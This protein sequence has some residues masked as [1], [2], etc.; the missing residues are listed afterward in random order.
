MISLGK[1]TKLDLTK[2]RSI[3]Q[4]PAL[5]TN[6]SLAAGAR[7]PGGTPETVSDPSAEK[8][9]TTKPTKAA[10]K[11]FRLYHD[12][13]LTSFFRRLSFTPDGSML[14]TPA[15]QYKAPIHKHSNQKEDEPGL[16][17]QAPE[18]ETRNTVYIYARRD[19][20]K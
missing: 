20:S 15:G 8:D 13:T 3:P 5:A 9:E 16:A 19:F 10:A 1:S 6:T 2:L 7:L 14:L 17:Y 18:L 4:P 12:E 11:S